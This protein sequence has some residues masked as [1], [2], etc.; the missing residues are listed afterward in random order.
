MCAAP[1]MKTSQLA[2]AMNNEGLVYAVEK[3]QRRFQSLTQIMETVGATCVKT[4]NRD[5]LTLSDKEFPDVEYILLDP[6]CTGSGKY[7]KYKL[8]KIPNQDYLNFA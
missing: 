4:V 5:V 1:G 2:A 7:L 6:S 3:D 8:S